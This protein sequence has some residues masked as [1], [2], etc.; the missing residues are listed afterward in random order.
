MTVQVGF[1]GAG[2]RTVREMVDLVRMPDVEIAALCD[3]APGRCD[4]AVRH[5]ND[6]VA[7]GA[8]TAAPGRAPIA[9]KTF[10]DVRAMLDSVEVDAVYVSLPPFAHGDIDHAIIEAGKAIFVEKPVALKM[11]VAR[12]IDAHIKES[13]VV[14]SVGYQSRYSTAIAKAR[15]LLDG[16]PVGLVIAIRLGGVPGTPWWRV[17]SRSGGM[18]IEQHTHGVD[19]CRYLAGE[20]ESVCAFAHTALLNDVPQ[21]DIADVNS[22]AVRYAGGAVGS[23]V[24]SCALARGQGAPANVAGSIHIIARG[25]T[26]TASARNL[27]VLRPEG[28]REEYPAEGDA[29]M[30]M[31]EAF[32]HAVA[33]G[34]RSGIR[35]DYADGM[36]SFEVTYA[37]NL[38][39][40]RGG[41]VIHIGQ[42]Y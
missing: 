21:L 16:V 24:N 12:D 25:L 27:I 18:L 37:A 36:R 42:G 10:T 5:I 26:V 22:V 30:R 15:E 17:Q 35:S 34:D 31:N 39:A 29:N 23:I 40:E 6:R 13:D 2:G 7:S 28:A 33:T 14:S 19:L 8:L 32:I 20:V 41:E 4:E 38:S 1:V 9:P 11:S 3:I